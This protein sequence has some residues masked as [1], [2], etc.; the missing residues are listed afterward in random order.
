[1]KIIFNVGIVLAIL[2]ISYAFINPSV[3]FNKDSETGI[4]FF[5]GEF[6]LALKKAKS[7]KKLVFLDIYATWC[8]PCKRLKANTFSNTEVGSYYNANFI[9]V[10]LNG[11][12]G[13]G[14]ELARKYGVKAYP[15]LLYIN[16]DGQVLESVTGYHNSSQF[17]DLGNSVLQKWK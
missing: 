12:E 3:D 9:N 6:D 8:G 15:T 17:I 16:G 11:E 1:M 5:K 10:A 14:M 2:A 13:E 4:S 7:E